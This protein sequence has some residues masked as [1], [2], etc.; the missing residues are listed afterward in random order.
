MAVVS[1][2]VHFRQHGSAVQVEVTD[3]K[4]EVPGDQ[5]AVTVPGPEESRT[6]PCTVCFGFSDQMNTVLAHSPTHPDLLSEFDSNDTGF[7]WPHR[8]TP[9]HRTGSVQP[10]V[11]ISCKPFRSVSL[12][13]PVIMLMHCESSSLA[14][15]WYTPDHSVSLN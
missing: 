13:C 14:G 7:D 1:S 11:P 10:E 15:S 2:S 9:V 3:S 5:V 8:V 6:R 4:S 12:I